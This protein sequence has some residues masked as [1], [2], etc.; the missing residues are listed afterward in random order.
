MENL[1]TQLKTLAVS[2]TANADDYAK[3]S[4]D[5][6]PSELLEAFP[7]PSR[8][9]ASGIE[10]K[11]NIVSSEFTSLCPLTKQPDFAT[12][13]VNYIPD[14]LCV[15]SKSYKLY[16]L[17]YRNRGHFHEAVVNK[18]AEDLIALLQ[19]KSLEVIGQFTP[20][21]GIPFWPTCTYRKP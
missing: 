12:I 7:S 13:I 11:L 10:L 15:E 18:I 3:A 9:G 19:P 6:E 1:H 4:G 2:A 17:T 5:A 16:L 14:Q 20:R 21:G 8:N